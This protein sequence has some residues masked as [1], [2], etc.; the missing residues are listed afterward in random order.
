MLK[1]IFQSRIV[2]LSNMEDKIVW[3]VAKSVKYLA[4]LGYQISCIAND[5]NDWP[6][7]FCW[8]KLCLPKARA[9][10]WL[11]LKGRILTDDMR[12]KYGFVGPSRCALYLN[13]MKIVN[14]LLV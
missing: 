6:Y 2:N 13:S 12:D 3:C 7:K 9:F 5:S 10:A 1:G 11:A 8:N 14:H 4:K